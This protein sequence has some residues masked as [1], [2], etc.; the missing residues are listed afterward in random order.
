VPCPTRAPHA[1][2]T[3]G[4]PQDYRPCNRFPCPGDLVAWSVTPWSPCTAPTPPT[5]SLAQDA[6]GGPSRA[7]ITLRNVTCSSVEG[8]PVPRA[9]C[10]SNLPEPASQAACTVDAQCPCSFDEDCRGAHVVC[11]LLG[12]LL[13]RVCT[14]ASGWTG[15]ECTLPEVQSRVPCVDGVV[16]AGGA[17]CTGFIDAHSGLCCPGNSTPDRAGNCCVGAEVD[18]CG[19]CGGGS[20]LDVQGVCCSGPLTASALCCLGAELDSCGVCGGEN[21]CRCAPSACHSLCRAML[22]KVCNTCC[23]RHCRFMSRLVRAAPWFLPR[24]P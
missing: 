22:C 7:G 3:Q 9:V 18:P 24:E 14:C 1:C 12:P 8:A 10:T 13:T 6:C 23:T 5:D 21:S 11:P 16:D 15:P 20:V 19:V 17:C 2:R 4:K